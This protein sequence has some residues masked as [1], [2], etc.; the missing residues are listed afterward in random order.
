M[1]AT[2]RHQVADTAAALH[3]AG[4]V[5]NHDGNVSTRS[6][7]GY[8]ATP[9]ATSKR[10]VTPAS[11]LELD[12]RGQVVGGRGKVF[13]EIGLHLAVFARRPDVGAVI[14]AH[15]VA[16][17]AI[18]CSGKNPIATP[19]IAEALV[20]LGPA[21]PLVPFAA[22]GEAAVAALAPWAELVDAVM[23]A[24][25]GVMAWGADLEQAYLRLEL[26]EHLARIALAAQ[27]LGGV[28][29]LPEATLP[30]LLQAR[31]KAS[32]G[33]VADRAI[34]LAEQL[35]GG[36]RPAAAGPTKVVACAPAPHAQVE[37]IPPGGARP[38]RPDLATLVREEIVR[39]L[40]GG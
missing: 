17:T 5:A 7:A 29:A 26:V 16:A 25:H 33:R 40:R 3:A 15:P 35:R 21:I 18:A 36:G 10:K 30:G 13:G 20:S 37:V 23:L 34:E 19:F 27:P 31:A 4:W 8:L 38:A 39:A 32:I 22:P 24:S 2:L 28:V 6:G 1:S 9:T 11:I 12:A 14:H